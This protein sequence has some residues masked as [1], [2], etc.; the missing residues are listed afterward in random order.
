MTITICYNKPSDRKW[1]W[2]VDHIVPGRDGPENL[3]I[4]KKNQLWLDHGGDYWILTVERCSWVFRIS[5]D[6][7]LKHHKMRRA[8]ARGQHSMVSIDF[9]ELCLS[10]RVAMDR[11]QEIN[12]PI[13]TWN[14]RVW[15]CLYMYLYYC[16]CYWNHHE[17]AT[18]PVS[19]LR[20]FKEVCL[21]CALSVCIFRI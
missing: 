12:K 10:P 16:Y 19:S 6:R 20:L 7:D 15:L 14:D 21:K 11:S 5:T 2:S 3:R 17:Y 8:L 4:L 13:C 1:G 9:W 18:R